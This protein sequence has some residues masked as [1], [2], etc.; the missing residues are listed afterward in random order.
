MRDQA[1]SQMMRSPRHG[2]WR[3]S[4]GQRN[5]PLRRSRSPVLSPSP[6]P[7]QKAPAKIAKIAVVGVERLPPVASLLR[8]DDHH[9][10]VAVA[11][12]PGRSVDVRGS[13]AGAI[14]AGHDLPVAARSL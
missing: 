8:A 9:L 6:L 13:P 12:C 14:G 1:A 3:G 4:G 7:F 2:G 5:R 10:G 11:A